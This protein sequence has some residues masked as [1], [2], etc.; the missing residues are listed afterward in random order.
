MIEIAAAEV[1][2]SGSE[3]PGFLPQ[4]VA[5]VGGAAFIG[6]L[7]S[8]LKVVPIVGFLLAGV[9][10]GPAQ[11][12]LVESQE[13]VDAA[14]EV[15]VI[16]LLFTIGLEFSLERLARIRRLILGGGGLQVGLTILVT[17]LLAMAGGVPAAPAVFTA[18][19]VALSSTA[20]VLK[21][22]G[23]RGETSTPRGQ[24]SLAVLIFQDL[25]VVA[26]VLLVPVLGGSGGGAADIAL[27][28]LRAVA[29]VAFV[30]VAARRAMPRLLDVV[31][32]TCSPEVFLLALVA[33]CFGTALVSAWAG[34]SVSLG[35][36]LAGLVV[37]D[38]RHGTHAFTEVLPLQILFSAA[39]FVSVGMLLD[40]GFLVDEPMLVVGAI[41]GIVVVKLTVTGVAVRA[42]GVA[43]PAA[44][45]TAF[46]LAQVGEFSFVLEDL[47]RDEGLSPLDLGADG[48]QA[49][50]A[51]T[52][53]LM[54][55]TPVLGAVGTAVESRMAA[56]REEAARVAVLAGA[57]PRTGA[58]TNGGT[59][60]EDGRSG[61]V[62]VAGY[63][64]AAQS[65]VGELRSLHT[66]FTVL[67]L[68]PDGA[69]E[70]EAEGIDVLVGDYAK[71]QLLV[72]AGVRRARAVVV[73]DDDDERT[74]HVTT[75]ARELSPDAVIVTRPRGEPDVLELADAGA[76]HVVTPERASSIGLGIA[77]R[78]A[79]G[80][81]EGP[82]PLSSVLRFRPD[83]D[84]PCPHTGAI[85][86]VQ[87]SAYGCEDCLRI[88]TTWVHLRICLGC[89]HVGCCD[90]STERHARAHADEDGHPVMASLEPGDDWAYCF[91][92]ETLIDPAG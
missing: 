20:I 56:R 23:E 85:Q 34:V 11:L 91:F 12:G 54:A 78:Y 65:L 82:R 79:L 19:L 8:R 71:R 26:M 38:S 21:L 9:V 33:V 7:S 87:P 80:A 53:V 89:G 22:L 18:F 15:G 16:L 3:V 48:S 59:A 73:A 72:D 46:L 52:V 2:A 70:A 42:V 63:G 55:L 76:D 32:R 64:T 5:I 92:D 67:T 50:V 86:P 6:Y 90:T 13:V 14:A 29:L 77:L 39:F 35:A 83:P 57:G 25:G 37:S 43:L 45:G 31:A 69:A 1:V 61:H 27:A 74:A 51:A 30:L 84:T 66:P 10:I 24:A 17:T 81:G 88:G 68:S 44:A 4:L 60:G 49:L 40:L 41:V 62:I 75:L 28:L 58:R 47:G 36:F